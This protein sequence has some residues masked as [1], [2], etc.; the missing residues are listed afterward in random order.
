MPNIFFSPQSN[1]Y[2]SQ[3]YPNTKYN[4]ST[5]L[6]VSRFQ[7]TGDIYRSL[8][9]F[10]LIN[11]ECS[12]DN[13]HGGA[14][15]NEA[16]LRLTI[17]RNQIPPGS[18]ININAYRILQP[19]NASKVTWNTQPVFGTS[20]EVSVPVGASLGTLEMNLTNLVRGWFDGSIPN[21][22]LLLTGDEINNRLLGFYSS[23]APN[24]TLWPRLYINYT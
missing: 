1:T 19:W 16:Y 13:I 20:P 24:I 17:A 5:S 22:G 23:Y 14:T 8:L 6:F 18:S 4:G 3:Y 2:I 21:A 10:C 12:S 9:R 15:I 7:T 11:P